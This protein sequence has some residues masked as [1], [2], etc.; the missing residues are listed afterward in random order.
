[1]S[2][3]TE[4]SSS[5]STAAIRIWSLMHTRVFFALLG[6]A[7]TLQAQLVREPRPD[8]RRLQ[9]GTDS[10]EIFVVRQGQQQRTG[11]IVDRLDTLRMNG[12]LRIQRIYRRID[13]A[14]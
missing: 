4:G 12:E 2:R 3:N 10:L 8:G 14:L 6:S 9:L 1:M 13:V 5:K 7:V 11:L